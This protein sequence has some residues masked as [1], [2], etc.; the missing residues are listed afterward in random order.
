[1]ATLRESLLPVFANVAR[2]IPADLGLRTNT[3]KVRWRTWTGGADGPEVH[4]GTYTDVDLTITPAPKLTFREDMRLDT[5][6][7]PAFSGGGYTPEQ[8]NPSK[9]D[10]DPGVE[11]LWVIVSP[12]GVERLYR[13]ASFNQRRAF[14][15]YLTLEPLDATA[16]Y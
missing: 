12:D 9:D 8:I 16:P 3:V 14:G 2:K 6:V 5:V 1:M 15:Y 10:L 13:V 11:H 4:V 7:T